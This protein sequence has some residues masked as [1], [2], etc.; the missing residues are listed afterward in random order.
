[1][2]QFVTNL[3]NRAIRQLN[4]TPV[5]TLEGLTGSI[6]CFAILRRKSAE[7]RLRVREPDPVLQGATPGSRAIG[8][9]PLG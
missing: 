1:M 5:E 2:F 6:C 7:I 4:T 8:S 3:A 9:L